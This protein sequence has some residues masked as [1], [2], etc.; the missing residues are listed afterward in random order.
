MNNCIAQIYP[1]G[2][3]QR[4]VTLFDHAYAT[5]PFLYG[6]DYIAGGP[7][8]DVLFGQLGN[9]MMQG[10]GYIGDYGAHTAFN[11]YRDENLVLHVVPS[12]EAETDGDDYMEGN[13]GDDVLFGNLGQDDL[14]GGSSIYFGLTTPEMRPDGQDLLFGGAGTDLARE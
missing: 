13:G 14:V 3:V 10:D 6:S 8:N 9:D 12:F 7:G 5:S 11:A 2:V 1:E 4:D